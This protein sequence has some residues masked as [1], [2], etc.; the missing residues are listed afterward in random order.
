MRSIPT[1]TEISLSNAERE[2]LEALSRCGRCRMPS[3]PSPA[4]ATARTKL[5][6][7]DR[8]AKLDGEARHGQETAR[9]GREMLVG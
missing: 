8:G 6:E 4:A 9:I 5:A 2:A 1:A 7:L 3:R